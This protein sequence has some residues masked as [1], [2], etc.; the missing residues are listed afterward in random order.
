MTERK[1]SKRLKNVTVKLLEGLVVLLIYVIFVN[2]EYITANIVYTIL[3]S[4]HTF[5]AKTNS[6]VNVEV[7]Q[8][9]Y[10]SFG[11][12]NLKDCLTQV[13]IVRCVYFLF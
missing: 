11:R 4:S 7:V 13:C 10:G 6:P 5:M 2:N 12:C 3:P 8:N 9:V 1:P